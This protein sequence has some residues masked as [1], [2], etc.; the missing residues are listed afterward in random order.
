MTWIALCNRSPERAHAW[1]Q[2]AAGAAGNTHHPAAAADA[3]A[4]LH[5]PRLCRSAIA[6][7]QTSRSRGYNMQST[8]VP[9]AG[10]APWR[11]AGQAR[12]E[13]GT[14]PSPRG[15]RGDQQGAPRPARQPHD[16]LRAACC[17]SVAFKAQCQSAPPALPAVA[18]PLPPAALPAAP[19][20]RRSTPCSQPGSARCE[21]RWV[22]GR[23]SQL[24]A[25]AGQRDGAVGSQRA[26]GWPF[27][28]SSVQVPAPRH[29]LVCSCCTGLM[30][31]PSRQHAHA[32]A[33]APGSTPAAAGGPAGR[34]SRAMASARR[35]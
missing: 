3:R 6:A 10:Q 22:R 12:A 16:V 4:S 1:G 27:E 33:Q 17:R 35:T 28:P 18:P 13:A 14:W 5:L 31:T 30:H 9:A 29:W 25:S 32:A 21:R 34:A 7:V 8:A 2:Q 19:P 23:L 11:S 15:T 24:A 26:A 20:R